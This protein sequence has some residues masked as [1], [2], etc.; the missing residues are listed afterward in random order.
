MQNDKFWLWFVAQETDIQTKPEFA[1]FVDMFNN[2][3]HFSSI[4]EVETLPF[5]FNFKKM[6]EG[7]KY[8]D[9]E[10]VT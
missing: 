3:S 9:V 8:T 1:K 4:A 5:Q 2:Q 10:F 6:A 7:E